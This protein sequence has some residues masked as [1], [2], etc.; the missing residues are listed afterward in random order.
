M[1]LSEHVDKEGISVRDA[2]IDKAIPNSLSTDNL[3]PLKV[4]FEQL[5]N[6]DSNLIDPGIDWEKVIIGRKSHSSFA[7][8]KSWKYGPKFHVKLM[9]ILPKARMM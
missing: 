8:Y 7:F 1:E 4:N 6:K 5:T 2:S 3:V 9:I